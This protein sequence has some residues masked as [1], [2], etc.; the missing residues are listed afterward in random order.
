[1]FGKRKTEKRRYWEVLVNYELTR[2]ER[3]E[4]MKDN[5]GIKNNDR[6]KRI[7]EKG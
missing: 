1:M 3:D 5:R 7:G 2:H 4:G 6:G